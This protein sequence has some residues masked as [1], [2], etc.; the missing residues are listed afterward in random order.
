MTKNDV[1]VGLLEFKQRLC[2]VSS[3]VWLL[4]CSK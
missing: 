4:L 3:L 2:T 1:P